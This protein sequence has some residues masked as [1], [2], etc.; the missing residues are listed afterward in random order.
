MGRQ[1]HP[2]A[3]V[4]ELRKTRDNSGTA[5]RGAS[6]G[7][8]PKP[9]LLDRLPL[10]ECLRL[11]V[12]DVDFARNEI[13]VWDGKGAKDCRAMLPELRERPLQ[14]H[15]CSVKATHDEGLAASW[16]RVLMSDA[17]THEDPNAA[18]DR[19]WQWVFL[20]EHRSKNAKTDEQGR[21]HDYLAASV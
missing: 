9:K 10:K 4:Q 19:R 8:Q 5:D 2:A 13:I 17:L 12:K 18:A 14:G 7:P 11:C 20:T 3:R 6:E 21:H 16:N 1:A 15:L